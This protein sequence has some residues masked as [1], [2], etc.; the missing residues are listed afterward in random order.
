MKL[1]LHI[2]CAPCSTATIETWR[3]EGAGVTGVY[4]NPNIHPFSEHQRR[5]E[6][7]LAYAGKIDLPLIGEPRYDIADWLKQ[8][9]GNQEK[10]ERCRICIGQRLRYTASL[11]AAGG[12]DAF[13]T[14]LS[15]S[16]WQEHGIIREEGEAAAAESD[17]EFAYRDLRPRF[18]R[19]IELSREAGLYRQK[20][21]GC[22]FSEQEAAMQ[23]ARR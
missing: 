12:F 11:A 15:I 21:C 9:A 20:Y 22:V 7:L 14:T 17:I 2:C 3:L 4:F 1:L 16:P 13:S 18:R 5:Y 19:S 10:G 23:R 6:T 8:I